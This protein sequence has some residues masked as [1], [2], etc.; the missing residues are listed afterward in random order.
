MNNSLRIL[1]ALALATTLAAC[2]SAQ[3][4]EAQADAARAQAD[5]TAPAAEGRRRQPEE[6][7]GRVAPI[8]GGRPVGVRLFLRPRTPP[9]RGGTPVQEDG[10]C[11]GA[12]GACS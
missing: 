6:V 9:C 10:R 4:D 2:D 1:S 12:G 11:P 5:A 8:E 3:R 7:T